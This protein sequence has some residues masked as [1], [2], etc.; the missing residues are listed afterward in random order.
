[1]QLTISGHQIDLTDSMKNYIGEKMQRIERH[2][3]HLNSIDVVL[4]VE[5]IHHKAEATVNAKGI[6]LHAH[7]DS[8]NMYAS[9]DTLTDRLDSQ[10]RKH[11]EK[12][13]DHHRGTAPLKEQSFS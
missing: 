13:T 11:K 7:A 8:D 1:M 5:K 9:I 12:L 3:D 2:F 10:V 4:H 6:T